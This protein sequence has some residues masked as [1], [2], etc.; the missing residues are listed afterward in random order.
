MSAVLVRAYLGQICTISH[1]NVGSG[2]KP[3]LCTYA[4]CVVADFLSSVRK[5]ALWLLYV[6]LNNTD[7]LTYRSAKF[8]DLHL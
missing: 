6:V 2:L 7:I 1:L 5:L 4:A 8:D 3:L